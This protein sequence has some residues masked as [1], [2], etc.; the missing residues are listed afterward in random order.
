MTSQKKRITKGNWKYL[1]I[2][3]ACRYDY[4]EKV[5]KKYLS[6]KL[7]KLISLG[8]DTPTWLKKIFG[9]K[10]YNDIVYVSANPYI[11]SWGIERD[12]FNAI[13]HF[14]K[15][16][17]VWDWGWDEKTKTV[18]PKEVNK[19]ALKAAKLHPNKRLII[20][21]IQPHFPFLSLGPIQ[22]GWMR[23]IKEEYKEKQKI[24]TKVR[25]F[26][27]NLPVKVFGPQRIWKIRRK[28]G[29]APIEEYEA[30]AKVFGLE[31]LRRTYMKNLLIALR[32]VKKLVGNLQGKIVVTSDHGDILGEN[33]LYGHPAWSQH[34]LQ[35]E[36]PWLEIKKRR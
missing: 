36:V 2:L 33:G 15:I 7:E 31:G 35:L 27:G 20:H 17:D 29:L 34:P 10:K 9:D 23:D 18:H 3:D 11:N 30:V 28:L 16:Y 5:Y 25:W 21:Y 8:N 14:Y 32:Y 26:V 4:F 19:A 12:G 24:I 22:E 6:G 13:M 1:I